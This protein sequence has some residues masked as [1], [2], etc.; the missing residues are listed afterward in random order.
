MTLFVDLPNEIRTD[1]VAEYFGE[2]SALTGSGVVTC[3]SHGEVANDPKLGKDF[4]AVHE[5]GTDWGLNHQKGDVFFNIVL[6]AQDQLRQ[7]VAFALSQILVVVDKATTVSGDH[8]EPFVNY[9]DIFVRNA[10]GNYRDILKEVAYNPLMAENLS[11]MQSKST[12][13]EWE[14]MQRHSFADENFSREIMQVSLHSQSTMIPFCRCHSQI[15]SILLPF[16]MTQLFSTGLYLLNMDGSHK[17]DEAGEWIRAY[18]NNEIMSFARIWTG[19]DVRDHYRLFH[20]VS[21]IHFGG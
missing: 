5:L 15:I 20:F 21:S 17:V 19:L 12:A 18:T 6:T 11:F 16:S 2:T 13:H 10:F 9:H 14:H 7:R 3:G 8:T 4:V 1:E